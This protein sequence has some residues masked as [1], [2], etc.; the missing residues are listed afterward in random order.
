LQLQKIKK[1][2]KYFLKKLG[3]LNYKQ[4]SENNTFMGTVTCRYNITFVVWENHPIK[5][6][7]LDCMHRV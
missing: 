1:L 2:N 4:Y 5:L 3:P 7:A 6:M